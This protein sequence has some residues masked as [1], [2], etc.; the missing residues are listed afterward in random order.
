MARGHH[1]VVLGAACGGG[2]V[3]RPH[4]SLPL[5]PHPVPVLEPAVTCVPQHSR[6]SPSGRRQGLGALHPL[7]CNVPPPWS[8][9]SPRGGHSRAKWTKGPRSSQG[10]RKTC[11]WPCGHAW[12]LRAHEKVARTPLRCGTGAG[13]SQRGG[14]TH[15]VT[16]WRP[17]K[18][19][20][21]APLSRIY[22]W[23][24]IRGRF[25]CQAQ[26]L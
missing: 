22:L 12:L 20:E 16:T 1:T 13:G 25:F 24:R 17:Q 18:E 19:P 26:Q 4:V 2:C 9:Q 15:W 6:A 10:L 8:S 23:L 21:P 5:A 7:L 11:S 14:G 3:Q